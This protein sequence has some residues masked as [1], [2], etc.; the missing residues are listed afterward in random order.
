MCVKSELLS[1]PGFQANQCIRH[2]RLMVFHHVLVHV[3]IILTDIP[4]RAAVRDRPESEGWRVG[5]RA[6]ELPTGIKIKE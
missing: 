6:L 2:S 1:S 5:V 4:L 3:W